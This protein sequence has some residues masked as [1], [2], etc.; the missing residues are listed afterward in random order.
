MT[1]IRHVPKFQNKIENLPSAPGEYF[2]DHWKSL[3]TVVRR[4]NSLYVTPPC[5]GALEIKISAKVVGKFVAAV[6]QGNRG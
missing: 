3:V 5:N 1:A 6:P 2:W 4:G